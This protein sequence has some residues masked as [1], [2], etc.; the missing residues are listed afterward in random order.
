MHYLPTPQWRE[1]PKM[2][3]LLLPRLLI[4]QT[5]KTAAKVQRIW[6][7]SVEALAGY[8]YFVLTR[9]VWGWPPYSHNNIFGAAHTAYF[10][11]GKDYPKVFYRANVIATNT[12]TQNHR[13]QKHKQPLSSAERRPH[14][15]EHAAACSMLGW[16]PHVL[17]SCWEV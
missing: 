17:A 9:K 11:L 7:R 3:H 12:G 14:V 4:T 13:E 15:P 2:I 10:P 16:L 8:I 6:K 5:E 1:P